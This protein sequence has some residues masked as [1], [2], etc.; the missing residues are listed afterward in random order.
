[1]FIKRT[2]STT[3]LILEKTYPLNDLNN[4][5]FDIKNI[6]F[7]FSKAIYPKTGGTILLQTNNQIIERIGVNDNKKVSGN[8]SDTIVIT[9]ETAFDP[10]VKYDIVISNRVYYNYTGTRVSFTTNDEKLPTLLSHVPQQNTLNVSISQP[11]ILTFSEPLHTD[12]TGSI[13]LYNSHNDKKECTINFESDEVIGSG[14]N[15]ITINLI[16]KL[17][18]N[19]SYYI[20]ISYNTFHNDTNNYYEGITDKTAFTFTTGS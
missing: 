19:T 7:K 13:D 12:P 14:T 15:E 5:A 18:S 9:P 20:L 11:I 4:I 16:K 3:P 10:F 2:I 17:L 1:M 6:I 8:G